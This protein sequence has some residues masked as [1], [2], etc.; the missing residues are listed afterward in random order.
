MDQAGRQETSSWLADEPDGLAAI[1]EALAEGVML[2]GS[3]GRVRTCN[4]AAERILGFSRAQMMGRGSADAPWRTVRSDGAPCP[5]DDH[6][7]TL[8][9]RTGK[10]VSNVILGVYRPDG[11]LAWLSINAGPLTRAGEAHPHAVVVTFTDV[12]DQVER[13]RRL[14]EHESRFRGYFNSPAVGVAV[15]GPDGRWLQVNDRLCAM[16]GY[17]REELQKLTFLDVTHEDD[18]RL[19]EEPVRQLL[20][21]ERDAYALDKRYVRKD[22]TTIW[23]LVSVSVVRAAGDLPDQFLVLVKDIT[24]RKE[25]ESELRSALTANERLV[26]ELK[27]ALQQVKTLSGYLPICAWCRKVRND[28]G[29]WEQIEAYIAE[30]TDTLFSHGLCPDCMKKH[31]GDLL[32]EEDGNGNEK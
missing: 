14:R 25:T 27:S 21:G 29:Y 13:H 2:I 12:S 10:A 8:A 17:P 7:A 4:P 24:R 15:V 30:H 1:V 11:S 19:H 22:G 5:V 23:A 20:T 18:R 28:A 6:P 16:L 31:Y 32:E 9:L 3:D 26:E